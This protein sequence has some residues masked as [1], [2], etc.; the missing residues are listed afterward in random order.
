MFSAIFALI[1]LPVIIIGM[2]IFVFHIS[3]RKEKDLTDG[4][5]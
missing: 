5:L 1:I 2:S 4:N 3:K